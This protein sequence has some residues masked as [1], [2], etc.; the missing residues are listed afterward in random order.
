M[1]A[2][3]DPLAGMRPVRPPRELAA[4]V[5]QRCRMHVSSETVWDRL[6]TS[7]L[8][9]VA[10]SITVLA[11]LAAN[12]GLGSVPT[13]DWPNESEWRSLT[14]IGVTRVASPG[15]TGLLSSASLLGKGTESGYE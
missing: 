6:A 1:S 5:V 9:R 11:L 7:R 13:A 10:W 15:W 12:F 2:S 4:Q 8:W 3:R 14:E